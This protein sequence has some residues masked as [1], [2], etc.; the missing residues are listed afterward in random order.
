MT[1]TERLSEERAEFDVGNMRYQYRPLG[2]MRTAIDNNGQPVGG[3][4]STD[5]ELIEALLS[6]RAEVE[7]LKGEREKAVR[8]GGISPKRPDGSYEICLGYH[9]ESNQYEWLTVVPKSGLTTAESRVRELERER[10]ESAELAFSNAVRVEALEKE[11]DMMIEVAREAYHYWYTDN[12]P[13]VGKHLG[14][15]A[16]KRG[17]LP[18]LDATRPPSQE[19]AE[20]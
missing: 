10:D 2:W 7:R 9:P 13:K 4:R 6:L 17:Y 18:K 3:W 12:D 16:G 20:G 14:A 11:R 8:G 1:D 19:G 15:L 5:D